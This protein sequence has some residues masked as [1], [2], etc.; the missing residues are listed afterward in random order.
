MLRENGAALLVAASLALLG[1]VFAVLIQHEEA[2]SVMQMPVSVAAMFGMGYRTRRPGDNGPG[3]DGVEA[4]VE[5]MIRRIEA[6]GG[7][8]A[9]QQ[10]AWD[11]L[12]Y[13]L[14]SAALLFSDLCDDLEEM[15]EGRTAPQHLALAEQSIHAAASA[16]LE[17]RPSFERF[18]AALGAEQ[19]AMLDRAFASAGH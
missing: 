14:R 15:Q 8:T 7:F 16:M 13:A 17:V 3:R 5:E 10:A 4:R 12:V 19:K 9:P 6:F 18:Y 1:T 2:W 11:D